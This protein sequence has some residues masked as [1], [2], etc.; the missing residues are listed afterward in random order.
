MCSQDDQSFGWK[1]NQDMG[2]ILID[3][4]NNRY[5]WEVINAHSPR[6]YDGGVGHNQGWVNWDSEMVNISQYVNPWLYTRPCFCRNYA[7]I[8][9]QSFALNLKNSDWR[10]IIKNAIYPDVCGIFIWY[11]SQEACALFVV[12]RPLEN[13]WYSSSASSN[14]NDCWY[15]GWLSRFIKHPFRP[16]VI[17]KSFHW[18]KAIPTSDS[19]SLKVVPRTLFCM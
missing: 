5:S 8:D 4:T 7:L 14:S 6:F 15:S 11:P 2:G 3:I 12:W 16:L 9:Y 19:V 10:K 1:K 13:V 18:R 17:G